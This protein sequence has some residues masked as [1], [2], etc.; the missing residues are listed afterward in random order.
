MKQASEAFFLH[1]FSGKIIDVNRQTCV[2][3]GF[4][5]EELLKMNLA[6]VDVKVNNNK[7]QLKYWE[8]LEPYE[9]T[10]FE[11]YHKRKD[12]TLFP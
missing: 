12:G 5:R 4:S 3:L 2:S 1:D 11:S 9:Y 8:K 10:T 7:H 6:D